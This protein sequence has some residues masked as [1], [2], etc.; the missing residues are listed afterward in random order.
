MASSNVVAAVTAH[1][2]RL[3]AQGNTTPQTPAQYAAACGYPGSKASAL[4]AHIARQHKQGAQ[5]TGHGRYPAVTPKAMLGLLQGGVQAR[6][7]QATAKQRQQA[8]ALA[9]RT[10]W[11]RKASSSGARKAT[12]AKATPAPQGS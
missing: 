3:V 10:L 8:Q 2:Q 4:R 9:K 12:P 6:A 1:V 5:A 11:A 7:P